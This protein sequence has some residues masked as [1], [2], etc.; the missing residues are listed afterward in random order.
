M[1]KGRT[2]QK[3]NLDYKEGLKNGSMGA[4]AGD[5]G[6]AWEEKGLAR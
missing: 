5:G 3:S 2:P 6:G 4:F 1:S